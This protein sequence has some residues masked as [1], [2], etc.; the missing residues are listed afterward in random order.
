MAKLPL[1]FAA[2]LLSQTMSP[3]PAET[4][5]PKSVQILAMDLSAG[6]HGERR[7]A[8]RELRR[9]TRSST[10]RLERSPPDSL[11]SLEARKTLGELRRYALPACMTQLTERA[12]AVY[13]AHILAE[14]GDPSALATIQAAIDSPDV[15]R[16]T[17]RALKKTQETLQETP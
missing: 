16:R 3:V 12:T 14:L 13:C 4:D 17:S 1:L 8:G 15:P 7:F 10:R 11:E 5:P 9:Q 2:V 6:N